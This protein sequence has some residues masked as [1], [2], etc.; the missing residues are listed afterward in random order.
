LAVFLKGEDENS[1][2]VITLRHD[3]DDNNGICGNAVNPATDL[4]AEVQ[5]LDSVKLL[6]ETLNKY[7]NAK[8][9]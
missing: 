8:K 2:D 1:P 7:S 9:L 5:P 6:L 4:A 3:A